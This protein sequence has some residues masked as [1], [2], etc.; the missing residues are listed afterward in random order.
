MSGKINFEFPYHASWGFVCHIFRVDSVTETPPIS[1][2]LDPQWVDLEHLP[3]NEMWA[4][5]AFWLALAAK[6]EHF[7]ARFTYGPDHEHLESYHV[8]L[9]GK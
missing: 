2:E 3:K 5:N 1:D 7:K 9:T 8:V 4:D 6:G